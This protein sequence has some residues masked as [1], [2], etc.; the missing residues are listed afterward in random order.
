MNKTTFLIEGKRTSLENKIWVDGKQ[1][2][3]KLSQKIRNHSPDGFNWGYNGSGPAQ[4]ALAICLA[5]LPEAWMAQA[6]Y[7]SFK[8]AYVSKWTTYDFFEEIDIT[9]FLIDNRHLI[10]RAKENL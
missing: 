6:L 2:D 9:D 5:I 8:C 4:A 7:Q 10:Q 3:P 1:L